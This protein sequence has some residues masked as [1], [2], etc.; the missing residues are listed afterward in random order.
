MSIKIRLLLGFFIVCLTIAVFGNLAID[1]LKT[2]Q[3]NIHYIGDA[4]KIS[5]SAL[6]LNVE[7]F[8][9]QLEVWEY[10]FEPNSE[11]L[12]AFKLHNNKLTTLLNKLLRVVSGAHEKKLISGGQAQIEKIAADLKIVR[13]DWVSLFATIAKLQKAKENGLKEGSKEY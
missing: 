3:T 8:Y 11:R 9:T 4:T 6:D 13:E 1:K 2:I 5:Q 7:N 12:K 10:A